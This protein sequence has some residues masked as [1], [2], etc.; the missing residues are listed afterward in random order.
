MLDDLHQTVAPAPAPYRDSAP[1]DASDPPRRTPLGRRSATRATYRTIVE[2]VIREMSSRLGEPLS[3][4]DMAEIAILSP[5]HF[6]RVFRD[7][8]GVPPQK[9]QAA[10]RMETAKRLL[11]T[12][13]ISVTDLCFEVGYQSLG[14][15]TTHFTRYVGVSPRHLR[16]FMEADA[17]R[18]MPDFRRESSEVRARRPFGQITA[19]EGFAGPIFVGL[20]ATLLPESRPVACSI[21]QEPG[22]Y[23]LDALPDGRYYLFATAVERPK[24]SLAYLL[25]EENA[26]YVGSCARPLQICKGQI[27]GPTH[28]VLRQMELTD[29]PILTALPLMFRSQ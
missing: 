23:C 18:S 6:N 29:P 28:I 8:T 27:S 9:F 2:R 24:S 16:R 5:Y 14:T 4:G 13:P 20:F 1:P 10:L 21:L 15:F 11:L 25:P 3:L 7:V 17:R 19:S 26:V 12:T 22:T